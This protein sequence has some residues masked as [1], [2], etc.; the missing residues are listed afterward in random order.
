MAE[1]DN[2]QERLRRWRL[3]LGSA[4]EPGQNA[5]SG[6]AAS[7]TGLSD[8]DAAID[9]ALG[10][11][12]ETR[13][14]TGR[15]TAGLGGSAPSVHR[16]LGDIRTYFPTPVVQ[17]LQRDAMERLGLRQLLLEPEMLAAIQPDVHLVGTLISLRNAMP[18]QTRETAR[19]VVRQVVE[20]IERRL[21]EQLHRAVLGALDRS[22]RNRRPRL[23]DVDWPATIR[24]NLQHYQPALRTIIAERLIGYARRRRIA[25]LQDVILL[26]DQSGSMASSVVYASVMAAS[27]A[28]LRAVRTRLVVFDTSVVDLTDQLADPVD[29]L[30]ATQLGGGTDINRAVAYGQSLVTRP[31]DTIMVLVSDLIEG[32]DQTELMHRLAAVVDSGVRLVVLLALS[33]DG[34][35]SYD[36]ELAAACAALGA[37]AFACTPDQFPDLLASAIRRENV[38]EWVTRNGLA[39]AG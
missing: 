13:P 31:A 9:E 18:E 2:S 5:Q 37:P 34:A 27:L 23:A 3:V 19:I 32:G 7:G 11:V 25:A 16:W 6:S 12:Y 4:A 39:S 20:E 24:A 36:H 38:A 14:G 35:P 15:R 17:V 33:D 26:V 1:R 21:T 29:V 30:F 28:S 8:R 22:A 10:A